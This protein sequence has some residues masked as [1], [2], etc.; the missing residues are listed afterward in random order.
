MA[1]SPVDQ[2]PLSVSVFQILL[3]LVDRDLHGYA[4]IRDIEQRTDGEVRLTASTLYGA[5]ARMLDAS[6]IE[7]RDPEPDQSG[8]ATTAHANRPRL[9]RREAERLERGCGRATNASWRGLRGNTVTRLRG[10]FEQRHGCP[11]PRSIRRDSPTRRPHSPTMRAA[12]EDGGA[13]RCTPSASLP[14][15]RGCRSA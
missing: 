5:V 10:G 9:L 7:E 8:G 14:R 2:L 13:R 12:R 3:S 1:P 4:L 15:L 6:L 11:I